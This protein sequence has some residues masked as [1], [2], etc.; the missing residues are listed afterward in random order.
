MKTMP[1]P[2][3]FINHVLLKSLNDR[4]IL[5]TF[6]VF[7]S[8]HPTKCYITGEEIFNYTIR[9]VNRIEVKVHPLFGLLLWNKFDVLKH[10]DDNT[11]SSVYKK[12]ALRKKGKGVLL[13]VTRNGIISNNE[14]K[15][16]NLINVKPIIT[17]FDDILNYIIDNTPSEPYILL[18]IGD[19][20]KCFTN[21]QYSYG[22][23]LYINGTVGN[24]YSGLINLDI[25]RKLRGIN[26]YHIY[27]LY[28]Y[29]GLSNNQN[30]LIY[31]KIKSKY[32]KPEKIKL[33]EED[34]YRDERLAE[35]GI[36]CLTR[37][38]QHEIIF[39][40]NFMLGGSK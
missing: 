38:S 37:L 18:N 21:I 3:T 39:Y 16:L 6:K 35:I 1:S 31:K 11:D 13:L 2:S 17:D 32:K 4:S 27:Y 14:I 10:E 34:S 22:R 15:Q 28:N 20:Y 36:D 33:L 19:S 23:N 8:N 25:L 9:D 24:G 5:D 40:C 30:S 12:S 26:P 29:W 7:Q